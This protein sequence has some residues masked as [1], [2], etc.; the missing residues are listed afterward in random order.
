MCTLLAAGWILLVWTLHCWMLRLA[1]VEETMESA[2][3]DF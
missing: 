2:S 1:S 3:G